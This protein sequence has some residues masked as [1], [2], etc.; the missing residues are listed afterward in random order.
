M[1]RPLTERQREALRALEDLDNMDSVFLWWRPMDL[2]GRDGSHH[3]K[4][5]AALSRKGLVERY[6]R[7]M[8]VCRPSYV[9]RITP[10]GRDALSGGG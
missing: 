6:D 10:A 1:S 3:A 7:S 9:Y 5:L 8:A 4:T 2:G